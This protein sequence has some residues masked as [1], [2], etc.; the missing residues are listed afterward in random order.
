[1][2][3]P[4]VL[5][6]RAFLALFLYGFLVWGLTTLWR[7]IRQQGT[8]LAMRKIPPIS[9]TIR[10]ETQ[11][12]QVRRFTRA[13]VIIGRD[14][15]SDCPLEDETVSAQHVRLSY[16]HGQ[17]WAEDIHS[18]NGTQLNRQRLSLPT[19]IVSEDEIVCGQ[20]HIMIGLEDRLLNPPTLP[21]TPPSET[22]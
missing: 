16:H 12:P 20:T 11:A 18:T 2:S 17:W 5:A 9:L 6:L 4:L 15:S 14:P 3:G 22:E 19:V 13:E 8:A 21:L 10:S 7:N 1:M